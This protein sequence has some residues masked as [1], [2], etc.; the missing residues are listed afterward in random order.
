MVSCMFSEVWSG[1]LV[2]W[3]VDIF[4]QAQRMAPGIAVLYHNPSLPKYVY[5]S[6]IFLFDT[7]EFCQHGKCGFSPVII[8][9]R[10][11][12]FAPWR[13]FGVYTQW[14]CGVF[15]SVPVLLH[16]WM[17]H[18]VFDPRYTGAFCTTVVKR[19]W[20]V[21]STAGA[22][23]NNVFFFFG[24]FFFFFLLQSRTLNSNGMVL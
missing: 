2:R 17:R 20:V 21:W 10:M 19:R 1:N 7:N 23:D 6:Q 16:F 15:C 12:M 4:R 3:N 14:P 5:N 24:L 11:S 13:A 22:T 8:A 9:H 18:D